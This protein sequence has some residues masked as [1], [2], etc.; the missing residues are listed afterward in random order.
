MIAMGKAERLR[1]PA[2]RNPLMRLER[3]KMKKVRSPILAKTTIALGAAVALAGATTLPTAVAVSAEKPLQLAACKAC[4]PCAAKK[5]CNP[6]A[7]KNPCK[8]KKACNPCAAKKACRPC[9]P[10]K[11]K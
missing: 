5:A 8:A 7:G 2:E 4:K 10:C 3:L 11:A 6:C 9:K 1:V